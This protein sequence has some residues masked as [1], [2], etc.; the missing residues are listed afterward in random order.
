[1][2][3]R[4]PMG[5]PPRQAQRGPSSTLA[6]QRPPHHQRSLSQQYLSSSASPIRKDAHPDQA[7]DL[8]EATPPAVAAAA[9]Q[10]RHHASTPRRGGSKLRLE[11]A[12]S[13]WTNDLAPA[14][15]SPQ[16][17]T[18][19][20]GA[21]MS[22][23][24][25]VSA[26]VPDA[27]DADKMSPALSRA[28]Q[29]DADNPAVP[30]PRRR[31]QPSDRPA[32]PPRPSSAAPAPA[33]KDARPKAFAVETPA[34]APRFV[35]IHKHD[36][37]NRDP[38][39]KGLHM[40]H[41]DFFPWSGHH[42][43]DEW[44]PEAIQK[45][46]WD[47]GSQ[48][49]TAS[50][51][52]A[53]LPALKQKSGLNALSTIFM[54]VMNQRRFRGQI[55]TPS[56][57]KPPPRV[58]LTDTKREVW[59]KDLANSNISLRRLSR[60][61]PHGIRGRTLLDQCLN[62]SVPTERAV[63]L[64]K[65]VG[66]NEIRAFK[67]K[68]AGGAFVMGGE[69]KWVR[70]WT[71]FVE[72]FLEA[73]VS[74]FGEAD[75][76]A[77]VTYAIRLATSLYS[78]HL[79]DRDHYLDWV[80]SSLENSPQSKIPMWI[81]IAQITWADL[82]RSRKHGRR[83]AYTL[84][85]QLN[86]IHNDP[87]RDILV[88][89]SSQLISLLAL[90]LKN[91]PESFILP[92]VWPRH[93]D[94]LKA[95]LAPDDA[96]AQAAF[97]RV[98]GRNARLLVANTTSPPAG[99]QHLVKLLDSTIQGQ[100]ER[101][102]SAKCLAAIDDQLELVRAVVDWATSVHRPGLAKT[103]VAARLLKSWSA[104]QVNVTSV[105]VDVLADVSAG[106]HLRKKA[107]YRLV[108]EL[109][110][111]GLFSVPRYLQWLIGRGGLH[112]AAEIDPDDGPCAS[113][114]LVELPIHCLSE[115]QKSQRSNL[116]RRAGHY[117]TAD[118]A[119]DIANAL[120]C[121]DDTIGL[122]LH[123]GDADPQ[124]RCLPLKKLLRRIGNSN[125]AVQA[126]I[127]AHLR[128]VLTP[129]LLRKVE[130]VVA[131]STFNS[132][133]A[134]METARDFAN[135][136][137][138]LKSCSS[139]SGVDIL[140]AIADTVNSHVEV[141]LALGSADA[142]FDGLAG[143][144]KSLSR[145]Q[146]VAVRPLLAALASLAQ[147][148]PHRDGV[149]KQLLRELAQSDRSNA[150]DA[151]S[152]VS[153]S[154]VLQAQNAESEVSE[155]V[156][157]L[158]ASGNTVDPPTMNRLFRNII[159]KLETGWAKADGTRRV[160]AS[161][162]AKLR[163]FD[164]QHFDKLMA[165]WIS[166]IGTLKDRPRLLELFPVLVSLGCLSTS[167]LLHTANAGSSGAGAGAGDSL[168]NPGS[169][170]MMYLQELLQLIIMKLPR[171]GCL[172]SAEAYRFEIQQKSA[173]SEHPRALLSLIRNALAE[174]AAVRSQGAPEPE[175]PLDDDACRDALL[176]TLR[177]LVVADPTAVAS[178]LNVVSLPAG[179]VRIVDQIVTRLLVPDGGGREAQR[180]F[181]QL[182]GLSNEL[183][184]PFCQL[185][186]TLDLSRTQPG[187]GEGDE[188]TTPSRFEAFAQA[189]DRAIE[190]RNIMWTSML[191]CLS[192]D[193][194]RSLST[195]AHARF[196]DLMPTLKSP[197]FEGE[198]TSEH[199]IHLAEN[200]LGVV[201]AIMSGQPPSKAS[202][203]TATLV[204]KLCDLWEVVA[205]P[206][207]DRSEAQTK[208]LHHWLPALL[209]FIVLHSASPELLQTPT[210][211]QP[212]PARAQIA[213][214]HDARARIVLALCGLILELDSRPP[215]TRGSLPQQALDVGILLVDALTDEV[216]AQCARSILQ[217]PGGGSSSSSPSSD[218]RFYY[219]FSVQ[220]P[221]WAENL[222]LA[223]KERASIAYSAAARGMSALYG[224]GPASHERLSP[225][226]LR[227]WEVLSEPT[228]NVGEND[229]SLSLGLF[230][231]IKMQ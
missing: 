149:A 219:L 40:A 191:P 65:C 102:L 22:M 146:G 187:A 133:R 155:Q 179:A 163:I 39:S 72:Q 18:P 57:F 128:D 53:V 210:A 61:I 165:D 33:R 201:E 81:L 98:N 35:S 83:L 198:A 82:V 168:A 166:H 6:V 87:D 216:R 50:A 118:E 111:S 211:G 139:V 11:L 200:L 88:Q 223:H 213:P 7:G 167:I 8:A 2:T 99:R 46:T 230:E 142:L 15:E 48:N 124:R 110:R 60:T 178:I 9:A 137:R 63:W 36:I 89:L 136:S 84:L 28:S 195:Q 182:L 180:S 79:L 138:I 143:R 55:L 148:L 140:A 131:L 20:R 132:V 193:I 5:V 174:Y 208:V 47:R 161:L 96:A 32:A 162:L 25:S 37:P 212:G 127:G 207:Q 156:D 231:A 38:F 170:P 154:M 158:L 13:D 114:L 80:I 26:S 116:L 160:F 103:Y 12:N 109:V 21:S 24:M 105:V 171:A 56:T 86:V 204:E 184:M 104:V 31:P 45:G 97:Q 44:S 52:L 14:T 68:G 54:G 125:M 64:A 176:E 126:S 188:E 51:R 119:S 27:V 130:P 129:D 151:C 120:R 203:L 10:G 100:S 43:E 4:P 164:A 108:A 141:F 3:S 175:A 218:A 101:D 221:T 217:L 19:S 17:L 220:Q 153:D 169:P 159:P 226:V 85:G 76:K 123:L 144:L 145:E 1:M 91:N 29:P 67:R 173:R 172:D 34:D 62:K 228:P 224:I 209:R 66:A 115:S 117:S 75:W 122:S 190:A 225:Y 42:H 227:R 23:S 197:N 58:T 93:R 74:A 205:C 49:E 192:P 185:K 157:K 113:R 134:I 189:M 215:G 121:V 94:C 73:V 90:L 71:V 78:E 202:Q 112:E 186:L 16:S 206:E 194:T 181:D 150:I 147:R 70:D 95:F 59:L 199:R 222:K 183:T 77:R 214:H 41:A 30:L 229:T 177:H 135:L 196:L 106:D 107:V 152:P 92:S 69:S